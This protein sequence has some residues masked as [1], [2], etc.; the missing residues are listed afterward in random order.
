MPPL[1]PKENA[2]DG[3]RRSFTEVLLNLLNVRSNIL[4]TMFSGTWFPGK[5]GDFYWAIAAAAP[6]FCCSGDTLAAGLPPG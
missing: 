6:A 2:L 1:Q 3:L 4:V 5:I